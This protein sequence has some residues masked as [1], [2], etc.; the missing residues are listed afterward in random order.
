MQPE[1]E[2]INSHKISIEIPEGGTLRPRRRKEGNTKI[3]EFHLLQYNA[4]QSV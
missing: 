2:M 4:L 3:E 1:W